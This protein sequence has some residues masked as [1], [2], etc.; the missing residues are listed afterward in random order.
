[1]QERKNYKGREHSHFE[2]AKLIGLRAGLSGRKFANTLT[3]HRA[4]GHDYRSRT[5]SHTH[6]TIDKGMCTR[7]NGK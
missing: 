3:E 2:I 6:T 7:K 4:N 1:M 5:H